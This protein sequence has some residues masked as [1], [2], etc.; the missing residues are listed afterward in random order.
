MKHLITS[1]LIVKIT[2]MKSVVGFC[3]ASQMVMAEATIRE[4]T[5]EDMRGTFEFED[6]FTKLNYEQIYDLALVARTRAM[7]EAKKDVSEDVLKESKESEQNL[8]NQN[9]DIDGLLKKR[10]EIT[11]LR[12]KRASMPVEEL[13]G[14]DI[15]L[16]GFVLPLEFDG[17]LVKEFL[18]VP[19]VGACIHT[20]PPPPN[21]IVHVISEKAFETKGTYEAVTIT[22]SM[23]L[24][25]K[26]SELFLVDGTATIYMSYSMT[27]AKVEKY[28]IRE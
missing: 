7:L 11:E 4:I 26:Q 1:S 24:E 13:N 27:E 20:P 9:V 14:K 10:K 16:A 2:P 21:Q 8:V 19:W 25:N 15:K 5:W 22:G 28:E 12:K 3:L 6:P 17:K 18:L 23:Q